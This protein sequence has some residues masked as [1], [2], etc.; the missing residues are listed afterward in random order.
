MD[1]IVTSCRLEILT[2]P[3]AD[4]KLMPSGASMCKDLVKEANR[5]SFLGGA[6]RLSVSTEPLKWAPFG[7]KASKEYLCYK[8]VNMPTFFLNFLGGAICAEVRVLICHPCHSCPIPAP[9]ITSR[10]SLLLVTSLL[11][12]FLPTPSVFLPPQNPTI[13]NPVTP[14]KLSWKNQAL[15]TPSLN[16]NSF[17]TFFIT[18]FRGP[19][20]KWSVTSQET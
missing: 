13:K 8:I 10:L 2:L 18:Y 6:R 19:C 14:W 12:G 9:N 4:L 1:L 7:P 17:I 20:S 3:A 15:Q 5:R 16:S 11:I